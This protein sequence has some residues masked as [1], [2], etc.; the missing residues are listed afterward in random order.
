MLVNFI[1]VEIFYC[2]ND[3]HAVIIN[4]LLYLLKFIYLN[5]LILYF[6]RDFM[7]NI[8]TLILAVMLGVSLHAQQVN[9]DMVVIEGAT[10]FW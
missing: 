2:L 6:K 10:G 3:F 9:R 5:I 4:C 7:K 1:G 8:F